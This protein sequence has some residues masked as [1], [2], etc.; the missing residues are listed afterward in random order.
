MLKPDKNEKVLDTTS[1]I[2]RIHDNQR[3]WMASRGYYGD[4]NYAYISSS[5]LSKLAFNN[6]SR[7]NQVPVNE[8]AKSATPPAMQTREGFMKAAN[9]ALSLAFG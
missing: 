8:S 5:K 6:E 1:V 2:V 9:I 4:I 7:W 3:E